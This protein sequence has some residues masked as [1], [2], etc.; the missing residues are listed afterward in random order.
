MH[1]GKLPIRLGMKPA[2]LEMLLS[3]MS[4]DTEVPL[5]WPDGSILNFKIENVTRGES[6]SVIAALLKR[7]EANGNTCFVNLLRD[8]NGVL[9]P[10]SLDTTDGE[11]DIY[12][13]TI[14]IPLPPRPEPIDD[15]A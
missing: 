15:E 9:A 13:Y 3:V 7:E 1:R 6:N 12:K 8:S 2:E 11:D 4:S 14:T 10:A 5:V